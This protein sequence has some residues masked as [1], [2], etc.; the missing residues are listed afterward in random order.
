MAEKLIAEAAEIAK[1]A[2][3]MEAEIL[4][5]VNNNIDK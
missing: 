3:A 5:A 2:A 1:E 4:V